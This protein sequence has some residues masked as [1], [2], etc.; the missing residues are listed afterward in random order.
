MKLL[1]LCSLLTHQVIE[2]VLMLLLMVHVLIMLLLM[3]MMIRL[4]LLERYVWYV[5]WAV[6]VG[7]VAEHDLTYG[8]LSTDER[9]I[10]AVGHVDDELAVV[11]RCRQVDH[12]WVEHVRVLDVSRHG[13][14]RLIPVV[15]LVEC[16]AIASLVKTVRV[17]VATFAFTTLLVQYLHTWNTNQLRPT[18]VISYACG[19][20]FE[21][22][23]VGLGLVGLVVLGVLEQNAVHIRAGVL[24]EL[25]VAIEDDYDYFAL[26]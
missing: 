21:D 2:A 15:I 1:A 17:V 19:L 18:R 9:S 16:V 26:A 10:G 13:G 25:V 12:L 4:L 11:V 20:Y 5:M 14:Q 3:M 6:H 24:Q 8:R 23:G 22:V 7:C